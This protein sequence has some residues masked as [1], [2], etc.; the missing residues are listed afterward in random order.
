[1]STKMVARSEQ[2]SPKFLFSFTVH[3][4]NC[5]L[6]PVSNA[7][8]NGSFVPQLFE[9]LTVCSVNGR[10]PRAFFAF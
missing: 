9:N 8:F 4:I 10:V 3:V 5:F 1:M 6:N 7:A 2:H